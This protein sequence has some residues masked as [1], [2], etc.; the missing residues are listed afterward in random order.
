MMDE[1]RDAIFDWMIGAVFLIRM[2]FEQRPEQM[3]ERGMWISQGK[4]F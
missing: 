1:D 3:R 2:T 4:V